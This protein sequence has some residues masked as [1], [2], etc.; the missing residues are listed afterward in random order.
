MGLKEA[1]LGT[2]SWY[3]TLLFFAFFALL[4]FAFFTLFTFYFYLSNS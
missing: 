2:L 3:F 4:C 1:I